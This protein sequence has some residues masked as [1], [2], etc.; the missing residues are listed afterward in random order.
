MK[1]V[2]SVAAAILAAYTALGDVLGPIIA[3]N[4]KVAGV[5]GIVVAFLSWLAT[6]PLVKKDV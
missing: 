4:P 1:Y 3:A 5:A 6:S 2:V